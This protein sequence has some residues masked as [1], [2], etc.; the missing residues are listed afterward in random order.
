MKVLIQRVDYASVTVNEE[1]I[2]AIDQ[3]LLLFVG[4]DKADREDGV[5]RLANKVVGYRIFS[6]TMGKMNLNV[7]DIDGGILVVSQ[8]T[9]SADTGK[10]L[11]PS[12]SSA[13]P[14]DHANALY[15]HF[16]VCLKNL[17]SKVATGSFAANMQVSLRNNGPVTFLLQV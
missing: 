2:G 15:Q 4:I 13:A 11:R 1:M 12:F 10:G 5:Q 7:A 9:L 3:G 16:V 8:F 6:D 14:P 17:H